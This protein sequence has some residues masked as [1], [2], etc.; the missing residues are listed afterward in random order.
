M[1]RFHN[2]F[3]DFF[4]LLLLIALSAFLVYYIPVTFNRLL[5][6]L[7]L[8]PIWKSKNDYFWFAFLFVVL[9]APGG[10]FAESGLKKLYQLPI[11]PLAPQFTFSF[12]EIFI[13]TLLLKG[14][15]KKRWSNFRSFAF[16]KQYAILAVLLVILMILTLLQGAGFASIR[17]SYK[18]LILISLYISTIFVFTREEEVIKFF[19]A[20]FPFAFVA[21]LLQLYGLI[22]HQ[23][24][25]ALFDPGQILSQGV[26]DPKQFVRPIELAVVNLLCFFSSLLY[27]DNEKK[28]FSNK[29]LMTVNAL[30]YISIF[31][32][33]T[34]SWFIGMT[35]MYIFYFALN[36]R[37]MI[38]NVG[39][40]AIGILVIIVILKVSPTI[41]SQADQSAIRLQTIE[42]LYKGDI[43]AGNTVDRFTRR[44]PRVLE[45]FSKSTILFG[46]GFSDQYY[47]YA[48]GHVGFHTILLN[49][50]IV[51]FIMLIGFALTL[52]TK[53]LRLARKIKVDLYM[54]PIVRNLPLFVPTILLI[55]SSTQFWGFTVNEPQRVMILAFY[56][57]I[58]SLYLNEYVKHYLLMKNL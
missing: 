8:I 45:G 23:Q 24:L 34:R 30:S 33:A 22:Y 20:I 42:M 52:M 2:Q 3:K 54:K 35:V 14:I 25:V 44:G 38:K 7:F 9:D 47:D 5:F 12:Q 56:I 58:S 39:N 26:L 11:Y 53:P 27:L 15:M 18:T 6:I 49:S 29:Y 46:A 1:I 10:L 57:C 37:K 50:G 55:N 36:T 41:K 28:Y 13:F 31:L 21:L 32:T 51:G 16:R 4:F 43:T 19:K 40:Y 48:D 17:N